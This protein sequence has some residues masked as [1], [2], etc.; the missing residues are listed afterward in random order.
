MSKADVSIYDGDVAGRF[1][2]GWGDQT[3]RAVSEE[4]AAASR[5]PSPVDELMRR[6]H[7]Y[8]VL[9]AGADAFACLVAIAI[10]PLLVGTKMPAVFFVT[11]LFL[12]LAAKIQGLYDRDERVV[13]KSTLAEWRTVVEVCALTSLVL[14]VAW[15]LGAAGQGGGGLWTFLAL[16]GL[17]SLF[18][19]IGRSVARRVARAATHGERCLIVGDPATC[20]QLATAIAPLKGVVVGAALPARSGGWSL[21]DLEHLVNELHVHRLVLG[22]SIS[23]SDDAMLDTIRNAKRLGVRVSLFPSL[24]TSVGGCSTFDELNGLTLLG[25]SRL[26]LTR[27]S[28]AL[29]RTFDVLVA[30]LLL[31]LLAPLMVLLAL[32]IK[33]NSPGGVWFRQVRIGRDGQPFRMIKFR[34]MVSGA[35]QLKPELLG[36]NEASGGLFKIAADPRVT[37]AGRWIR[38]SYLDELPQLF[39]I[40]RGEMSLVGPRPLIAEEDAL[41]GETYRCRL[42]LTPGLTGPWQIRGPITTPLEEMAKLDYIYISNWSLWRDIDILF[43]TVVQV[44]GL[45]GQ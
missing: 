45:A 21:V 42:Q 22:P 37:R 17:M 8:R 16:A 39:N 25:V 32:W 6:E 29:K 20:S 1:A 14:A 30:A 27:S 43:K 38:R 44:I 19:T 28:T 10:V 18:A 24:L 13:R 15:R 4:S 41:V 26:G 36:R 23:M 5:R 2:P 34:S 31:L 11:P 9:L 40:L 12:I 35:E 33:F 7:L 3:G